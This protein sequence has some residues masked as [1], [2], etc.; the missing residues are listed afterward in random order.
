MGNHTLR[1][2]DL[3]LRY[4]FLLV[5]VELSR[6]AAGRQE[7]PAQNGRMPLPSASGETRYRVGLC[8]RLDVTCSYLVA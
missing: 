8:A 7:R 2:V 5:N 3:S 4:P 6:A 1:G